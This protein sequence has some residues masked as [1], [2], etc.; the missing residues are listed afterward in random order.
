MWK[1]INA[2]DARKLSPD[3]APRAGRFARRFFGQ[4]AV[5][6]GGRRLGIVPALP[7]HKGGRCVK[8]ELCKIVVD[9][10]EWGPRTSVKDKVL[11]INKRRACC[12]NS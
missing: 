3:M 5:L 10:L 4:Q 7:A 12:Q 1:G 2:R 6:S 8:L 11:T 9:K